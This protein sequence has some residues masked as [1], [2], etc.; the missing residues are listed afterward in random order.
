MIET[1]VAVVGGGIAGLIAAARVARAGLNAHLFEAAPIH[2]GRAKTRIIGGNHFNQ[3]PHALYLNGR[4]FRTL[5]TLGIQV[6]GGSPALQYGIAL[7][8]GGAEQHALPLHP[9]AVAATTMLDGADR[10]ELASTLQM[11]AESAGE[12][13]GVP[14]RAVTEELRPNVAATVEMV[15]R[16]VTYTHAPEEIDAQAMFEQIKIAFGGVRYVDGGWGEIVKALVRAAAAAGATL[17]SLSQV[18]ALVPEGSDWLLQTVRSEK[19]LAKAAILAVAP[20][21]CRRLLPRSE[22]VAAAAGMTKP[23]NMVGLDLALSRLPR[24]ENLFALG[25]DEPTYFAVH[26]ANA[27]LAPAGGAIVHVARYLAPGEQPSADHLAG[28]HQI[29][30]CLQP[31]WRSVEIHRQRLSGARVAHDFPTHRRAGRRAGHIVEDAPGLFLAGDWVGDEA[32]L[33]DASAASAEAA[34]VASEEYLSTAAPPRPVKVQYVSSYL[35]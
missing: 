19:V 7:R 30:D 23:V 27:A 5:E 11:I 26:S 12:Y 1:D 6:S 14:V 10:R 20:E 15:S 9:A 28:L 2:G 25:V 31:G 24:P 32:M 21:Q 16:L 18:K 17:F 33:S 8:S 4:L 3:G 29:L 13:T 22:H 35:A 34:A